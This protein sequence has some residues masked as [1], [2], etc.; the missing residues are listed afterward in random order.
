MITVN[1]TFKFII[2]II[3]VLLMVVSCQPSTATNPSETTLA[4]ETTSPLVLPD[5]IVLAGPGVENA[6]T[7]TYPEGD[8][9]LK[10]TAVALATYINKVIPSANITA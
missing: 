7:I 5:G 10:Y 4:P 6:C 9:P 8:V 1:K 3:L 2:T